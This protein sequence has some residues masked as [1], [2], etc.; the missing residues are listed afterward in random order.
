MLLQFIKF[1]KSKGT[2]NIY[3]YSIVLLATKPYFP[4]SHKKKKRK[5]LKESWFQ[6]LSLIREYEWSFTLLNHNNRFLI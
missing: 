6:K 3:T 2:F 1:H 4:L 5:I